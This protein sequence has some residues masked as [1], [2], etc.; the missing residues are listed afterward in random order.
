MGKGS[1]SDDKDPLMESRTP[2]VVVRLAMLMG[3]LYSFSL[4]ISCAISPFT[5]PGTERPAIARAQH[6][7]VVLTLLYTIDGALAAS[8][9]RWVSMRGIPARNVLIHHVPFVLVMLPSL[10]ATTLAYDDL[11]MVGTTERVPGVRILPVS[12]S[13]SL[14][15][16]IRNHPL[17]RHIHGLRVDHVGERGPLGPLLLLPPGVGGTQTL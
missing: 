9:L 15:A 16:G 10:L 12:L 2:P 6:A 17:M 5:E 11:H 1:K 8:P 14:F 13:L 4:G 3:Y 7:I